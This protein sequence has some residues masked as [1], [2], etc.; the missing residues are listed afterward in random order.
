MAGKDKRGRINAAVRFRV[1]GRIRD[2]FNLLLGTSNTVNF[3]FCPMVICFIYFFQI[4]FLHRRFT[5]INR[6]NLNHFFLN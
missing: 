1:L 6:T 3:S 5:H 4:H 2:G